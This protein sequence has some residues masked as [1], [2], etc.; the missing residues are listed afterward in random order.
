M[1]KDW[2][3]ASRQHIQIIVSG[4]LGLGDNI[5]KD[6]GDRSGDGMGKAKQRVGSGDEAQKVG[7]YWL[8]K[9]ERC[10]KKSDSS[11]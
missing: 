10:I 2:R 11:V 4:P 5:C 1:S 3:K 9:T 6:W 7:G 8:I